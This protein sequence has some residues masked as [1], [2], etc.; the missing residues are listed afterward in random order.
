[1]SACKAGAFIIL[2]IAGIIVRIQSVALPQGAAC[3]IVGLRASD[4]GI[5]NNGTAHNYVKPAVFIKNSSFFRFEFDS[6]KG[7]D[8]TDLRDIKRTILLDPVANQDQ[9]VILIQCYTDRFKAL[10]IK[11]NIGIV[12]I[13][14]RINIY[15]NRNGSG[16][17]DPFCQCQQKL[18][19]RRFLQGNTKEL[20]QNRNRVLQIIGNGQIVHIQRKDI[21][22]LHF[23]AGFN[24]MIDYL[25]FS[26][27]I[28]NFP[29]PR[30]TAVA[31]CGVFKIKY[32]FAGF[33]EVD[34]RFCCYAGISVQPGCDL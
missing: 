9:T 3:D 8:R 26:G 14:F 25:V 22:Y 17:T 5:V 15:S 6:A 16:R 27:G 4:P 19:S 28:G 20:R 34:G 18:P 24:N 31:G 10:A 30:Q 13:H 2:K 12:H 29:V 7:T 21:G 33:E 32:S 11:D 1:M 23:F